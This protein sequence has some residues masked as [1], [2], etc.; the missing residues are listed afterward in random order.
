[1]VG[2]LKVIGV[3]AAIKRYVVSGGTDIKAGEPMHNLGTMSS[4]VSSVNTFVL[5][6][7]DTPVVGTHRFG[8]VA[9][10]NSE[11]AGAGTTLEQFLTCACPAPYL[12]MIEGR[13]ETVANV[14]TLTELALLIGDTVLI[15]YNATGAT[16]GGQL[17]TIKDAAAADTAGLEIAGGNPALST[18]R[19]TIDARA[20]R[21][22]VA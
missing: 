22:D 7:A 9:L 14:D 18:L 4:G 8:G 12:G 1:M 20:Y 5:A 3:Q 17:Y 16:D 13:A 15:D 21:S 19:V 2:D 11:N 6:A 10:E